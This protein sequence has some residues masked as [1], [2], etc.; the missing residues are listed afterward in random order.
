[1]SSGSRIFLCASA[2]AYALA[3]PGFAFAVT[4]GSLAP[5]D[6][7]PNQQWVTD[8]RTHCI[9]AD[10][11]YDPDDS[12]AWQGACRKDGM[13]YGSGTL[14]FLNK[15]RV[16][17]TVSGMFTDGMP[18]VGRVV[19]RWSDG[20]KYE[21][22]QLGGLF[23][24]SGKYVSPKGDTLEGEW[25]MGVLNGKASA[26]WANG[27]RYDGDWKNGVSDGEGVEVWADGRRYE[28]RW[29]GGVPFGAIESDP[30][31]SSSASNAPAALNTS[32]QTALRPPPESVSVS[33]Q[34]AVKP[35]SRTGFTTPA[36]SCSR[37]RAFC[38]I[39]TM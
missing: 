19:A 17:Q 37:S 4:L 38:Q 6:G 8:P 29:R 36:T 11:Y 25:K 12:I 14:T 9:A 39:S 22:E 28:G 18:K 15:G 13:I 35:A 10:P 34:T 20:S 2:S 24:G 26:V 30:T 32:A 5:H 7:R 31:E 27:D 3:L 21:G 33:P 1:M 16:V 23:N